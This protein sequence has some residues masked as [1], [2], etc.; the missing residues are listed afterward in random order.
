MLGSYRARDY[1]FCGG[2]SI[3]VCAE[4]VQYPPLPFETKTFLLPANNSHPHLRLRMRKEHGAPHYRGFHDTKHHRHI[5]VF[6]IFRVYHSTASEG[7]S[8]LLNRHHVHLKFYCATL[9]A[10]LADKGLTVRRF[11]RW[12]YIPKGS[13]YKHR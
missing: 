4:S 5:K 9:V 11:S 7:L 2:G 12:M 8:P 6:V 10:N 3:L 13:N 1:I